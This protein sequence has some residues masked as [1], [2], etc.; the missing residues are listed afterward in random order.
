L[1]NRKPAP[2]KRRK[3]I[4]YFHSVGI[5]KHLAS[6]FE[7]PP[8]ADDA[9]RPFRLLARLQDQVL[10][11]GFTLLYIDSIPDDAGRLPLILLPTANKYAALL[12][13]GTNG[14]NQGHST[15][16]VISWLIAL[17]RENPFVVAG[18]GQDFVD[19]RFTAVVRDAE[20][21]AERTIAFCPDMVDQAD[22]SL[23]L[24]SRSDQ[25]AAVARELTESWWF[26]FW[27]D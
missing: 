4:V 6:H 20:R 8:A 17:D 16:A 2:W 27:W 10:A 25:V 3:G 24:L 14:I 22:A 5:V 9:E 18:C 15:E 7:E 11:E 19:G 26:G 12:A 1:F 21:V 23:A 13:C